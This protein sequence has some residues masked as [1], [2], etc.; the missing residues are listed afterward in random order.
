MEHGLA[1]SQLGHLLLPVNDHA[2]IFATCQLIRQIFQDG[3]SCLSCMSQTS[4]IGQ[5]AGEIAGYEIA[6]YPL[7]RN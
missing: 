2:L 5:T 3:Y 7:R 1:S 4:S 6:S